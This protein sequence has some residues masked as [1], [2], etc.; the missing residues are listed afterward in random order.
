MNIKGSEVRPGMV[1]IWWDGST[2]LVIGVKSIEQPTPSH[3]TL[4][5]S[6]LR[7]YPNGKV[8]IDYLP[9]VMTTWFSKT[10]VSYMIP[11]RN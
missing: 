10:T 2:M 4:Y 11:D 3:S 8:V 7:R 9:G 6:F 5:F 1:G